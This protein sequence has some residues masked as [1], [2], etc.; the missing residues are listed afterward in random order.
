MTG[1]PR[2][3]SGHVPRHAER[4]IKAGGIFAADAFHAP[5]CQV[6]EMPGDDEVNGLF[7]A[8]LQRQDLADRTDALAGFGFRLGHD[9]VAFTGQYRQCHRPVIALR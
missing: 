7:R 3:V 9:G 1:E 8:R 5:G 2:E 4:I 6:R